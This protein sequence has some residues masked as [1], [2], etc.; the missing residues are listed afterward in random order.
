MKFWSVYRET[1]ASEKSER[2]KVLL[3]GRTSEERASEYP[4]LPFSRL[5]IVYKFFRD[6][7]VQAVV[8]VET[9]WRVQKLRV[10]LSGSE[11]QS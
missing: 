1:S 11:G 7:Y 10:G 4:S 9:T 2:S 5:G 3:V 6:S 8:M